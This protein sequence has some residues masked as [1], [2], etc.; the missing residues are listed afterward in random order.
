MIFV[1]K[2]TSLAYE[3]K[4]EEKLGL[5]DFFA[6]SFFFPGLFTGPFLYYSEYKHFM[7]EK[8]TA[9][10]RKLD[11]ER[12]KEAWKVF[13]QGTFLFLFYL[14]FKGT[15]TYKY[16]LT[17]SYHNLSFMAKLAFILIHGYV[18][19]A[20]YY[21]CWT[22]VE[23]HYIGIGMGFQNNKDGSY[24][25]RRMKNVNILALEAPVDFRAIIKNWNIRTA[26]WLHLYVYQK[27]AKGGLRGSLFTF[28]VSAIWHVRLY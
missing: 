28:I 15:I 17:D 5:L 2:L 6:Y 8:D 22:L 14:S 7:N 9:D 19:R 3:K 10:S 18:G 16:V 1:Q 24:N 13:L 21:H 12:Q 25:W 4:K 27:A 26:E 11:G 23:V 20:R